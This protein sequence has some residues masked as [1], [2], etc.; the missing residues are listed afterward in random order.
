MGFRSLSFLAAWVTKA[1][2]G[3]P[4]STIIIIIVNLTSQSIIP[5]ITGNQD[6]D[7]INFDPGLIFLRLIQSHPQTG[8]SSAESLYSNVYEFTR[9]FAQ[10]LFHFTFRGI[11]NIDHL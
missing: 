11:G 3:K 1:F 7:I 10:H 4:A 9:I 2:Y 5:D 8:A 6:I